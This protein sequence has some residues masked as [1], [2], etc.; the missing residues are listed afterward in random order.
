M[1][2]SN[3]SRFA[4]LGIL[5]FGP[6]SGYDIR[7]VFRAGPGHFWQESYGQIYPILRALESEGL[8]ERRIE[9]TQEG[10]PP[11]KVYTLTNRGGQALRDWLPEPTEPQPPRNELLLKLFFGRHGGPQL[12][13]V[14]V[15][16]SRDALRETDARYADIE[17]MLRTH[18]KDDPDAVYQLMTLRYGQHV[19]KALLDWCEE[20]LST[21]SKSLPKARVPSRAE[22]AGVGK[23][24]AGR[25]QADRRP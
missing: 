19:T 13:A 21:L 8:V 14:H 25:R 9:H 3:K 4:V 5:T 24:A 2:R 20:S 1:A 22:K 10:R 7:K 6:M 17:H 12:C 23:R 11:R 15:R 18:C 16:R